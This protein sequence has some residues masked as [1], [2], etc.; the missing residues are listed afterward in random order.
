MTMPIYGYIGVDVSKHHLDVAFAGSPRPLRIA[1]AEA[2]IGALARRLARLPNPHLVCEATGSYTRLLS[3]EL[4]RRDIPISLVNPRNVRSFARADGQLAK[5]DAV[6]AALILRFAQAMHPDP[7]PPPDAAA[8]RLSD[9][10]RRRRQLVEI[11]AMEKQRLDAAGDSGIEASL[12]R[13]QA[14][15]QGEVEALDAAIAAEVERDPGRARRAEL[16]RSI[17]G[18]GAVTATTLVA[19]LPELGHIGA[20]QIAALVGV[21]PINQDS[22]LKR[23]QAHIGGGRLWV[24]CSLYMAALSAIRC[25]PPIRTFYKRLR[26]EGKPAKLA[27]VAAMRK[28]LII[29]NKMLEQD[30]PFRHDPA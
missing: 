6:D 18:V 30:R 8:L 12:M 1:N 28:L 10:V 14:F 27:I 9:L 21:A 15:L 19:E 20:K 23:G 24:R 25:N 17:P 29:A 3:T 13:H 5:T 11:L 7:S 2:D 16:L 4:A 22:G 26:A